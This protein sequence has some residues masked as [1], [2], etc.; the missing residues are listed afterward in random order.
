MPLRANAVHCFK[1]S[2]I[3][4]AI[5]QESSEFIILENLL[6]MNVTDHVR[7]VTLALLPI[8]IS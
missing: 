3:G 1:G 8:C 7:T 2:Y 6:F 4:D 5:G